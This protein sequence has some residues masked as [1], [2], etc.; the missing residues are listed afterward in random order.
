MQVRSQSVPVVAE[1]L[2]CSQ[3]VEDSC[4]EITKVTKRTK[5]QE[6]SYCRSLDSID[7]GSKENINLLEYM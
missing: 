1:R 5:V 3:V 6:K 7:L 2:V 4:E